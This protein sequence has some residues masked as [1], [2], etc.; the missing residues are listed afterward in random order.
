MNKAPCYGGLAGSLADVSVRSCEEVGVLASHDGGETVEIVRVSRHVRVCASS[1]VVLGDGHGVRGDVAG[2]FQELRIR[3]WVFQGVA[4]LTVHSLVTVGVVAFDPVR[5]F[6]PFGDDL[7][8]A[9][10]VESVIR[11]GGFRVVVDVCLL[12]T[13]DAAD[14]L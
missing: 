11:A 10:L 8:I 13:S 5:S 2:G 6:V 12:Y 7:A 3:V 1:A 9:V 4:G 14:E